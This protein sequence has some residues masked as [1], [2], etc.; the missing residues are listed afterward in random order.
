MLSYTLPEYVTRS[1]LTEKHDM[2]LTR[3]LD[4]F[5]GHTRHKLSAGCKTGWE[6]TESN[7]AAVEEKLELLNIW[8]GV[9][10]DKLNTALDLSGT[11]EGVQQ[12]PLNPQW[13]MMRQPTRDE[14]LDGA[15]WRD[16]VYF[17]PFRCSAYRLPTLAKGVYH[18]RKLEKELK[19]AWGGF[20]AAWYHKS[21]DMFKESIGVRRS[22]YPDPKGYECGAAW[23]LP[24]GLLAQGLTPWYVA[25]S[26]MAALEVAQDSLP[27]DMSEAL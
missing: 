21:P 23:G 22:I 14:M 3:L 4:L 15:T 18:P 16:F 7:I 12:H 24:A 10:N 27:T 1:G 6:I 26:Y 19:A 25:C 8:R 13:C 11:P 20:P 2:E 17:T 5:F 9:F